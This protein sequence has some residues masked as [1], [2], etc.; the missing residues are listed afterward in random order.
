MQLPEKCPTILVVDDDK[1][2]AMTVQR[3][4]RKLNL[5]HATKIVRDGVEALDFLTECAVSNNTD[6]GTIV[7]LDLNMPRMNG[8][9]FLEKI[10]KQRALV[11]TAIYVFVDDHHVRDLAGRFG[12]EITGYINKDV[13]GEKLTTALEGFSRVEREARLA[14]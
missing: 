2:F 6:V 14:Y 1:V 9:E 5:D 11:P 8:W 10:A 7:F 3:A 13:A 12:S 4:L